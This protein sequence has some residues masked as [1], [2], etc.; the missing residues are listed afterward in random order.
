LFTN[1]FVNFSMNFWT[2]QQ[3]LEQSTQYFEK[4]CEINCKVYNIRILGHFIQ[5]N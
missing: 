5:M 2:S 3:S 4:S 1:R